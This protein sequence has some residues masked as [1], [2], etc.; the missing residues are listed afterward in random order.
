MAGDRQTEV[1]T[2]S[3][4]TEK[5]PVSKEVLLPSLQDQRHDNLPEKTDERF[6]KNNAQIPASEI[7]DTPAPRIEL[8]EINENPF[9]SG[10]LMGGSDDEEEEEG[11]GEK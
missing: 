3:S 4:T 8:G 2:K 1:I 7:C 6:I 9:K 11:G 5:K 10:N